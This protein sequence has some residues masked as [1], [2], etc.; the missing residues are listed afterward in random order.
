MSIILKR[1]VSKYAI[2]FVAYLVWNGGVF[3]TFFILVNDSKDAQDIEMVKYF[4]DMLKHVP[5]SY[6]NAICIHVVVVVVVFYINLI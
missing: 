3:F 6:W 1:Y 5:W 2:R 4:K